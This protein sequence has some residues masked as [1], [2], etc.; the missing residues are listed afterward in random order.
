[1]DPEHAGA[2]YYRNIAHLSGPMLQVIMGFYRLEG[3]GAGL[4]LV[5]EGTEGVFGPSV[6]AYLGR[7]LFGQ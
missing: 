4:I 7:S 1:M 5:G 3:C 2:A 6:G